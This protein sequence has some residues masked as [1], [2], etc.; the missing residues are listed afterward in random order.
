MSTKK[1]T[2][3]IYAMTAII[4]I[5]TQVAISLLA[6]ILIR[7]F[8]VIRILWSAVCIG[9]WWICVI[10]PTFDLLHKPNAAKQKEVIMDA[11]YETINESTPIQAKDTTST[12]ERDSIR[13]GYAQDIAACLADS[14]YSFYW[15][16]DSVKRIYLYDMKDTNQAYAAIIKT[17][18][19]GRVVAIESEIAGKE[20]IFMNVTYSK[21]KQMESLSRREPVDQFLAEVL[22]DASWQWKS[23]DEN[24]IVLTSEKK[25]VKN[26][27]MKVHFKKGST[28]VSS[29]IGELNNKKVRIVRSVA[30]SKKQRTPM[31]ASGQHATSTAA[32]KAPGA[33][34]CERHGNISRVKAADT[35]VPL[36]EDEP[37]Q[38]ASPETK[39][40]APKAQEQAMAKP[41]PEPATTTVPA[42]GH[43]NV[44]DDP[45]ISDEVAKSNAKLIADSIVGELAE[46]A[47]GTAEEGEDNFVYAWPEG[48][49]T[50]REAEF[51]AA[52]ITDRGVFKDIEVNADNQTLH[53]YGIHL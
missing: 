11:H 3:N 48:I 43:L 16:G 32:R 33:E 47:M 39:T 10:K 1:E 2:L 34:N 17:D 6:G 13:A 18:I 41:A 36:V 9:M 27:L 5:A 21:A 29:I 38:A 15:A 14:A 26:L 44:T 7:N 49:Q 30:S 45:P 23:Y 51:L 50:L 40:V 37:I 28:E 24:S 25:G 31:A 20:V 4:L 8:I 22:P 53:F 46:L 35:A 42:D 12:Q 52:E 19:N